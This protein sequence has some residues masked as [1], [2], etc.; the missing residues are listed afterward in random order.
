MPDDRCTCGSRFGD[1]N[2]CLPSACQWVG[3]RDGLRKALGVVRPVE[4]VE[5]PETE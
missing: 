2:Y 5:L 1:D 4:D 3:I